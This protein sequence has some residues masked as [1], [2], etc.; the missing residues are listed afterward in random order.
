M[1]CN[2][3]ILGFCRDYFDTFSQ[4]CSGNVCPKLNAKTT[5]IFASYVTVVVPLII[6]VTYLVSSLIG[7]VNPGVNQPGPILRVHLAAEEVFQEND[8]RKDL[9]IDDIKKILTIKDTGEFQGNPSPGLNMLGVCRENCQN[10]DKLAIIPK[11]FKSSNSPYFIDRECC[12]TYCTSCRKE[13]DY[14][15]VND[16]VITSAKVKINAMTDKGKIEGYIV[17]GRGEFLRIYLCDLKYIHV[18]PEPLPP[19]NKLV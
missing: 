15:D 17:I 18:T 7:R 12:E 5:L 10:K 2:N 1:D 19:L 6:G 16:I 13:M 14:D 4:C 8:P 9:T 11:G 3:Q